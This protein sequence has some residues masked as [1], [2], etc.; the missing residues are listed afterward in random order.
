M[1]SR[2]LEI[3]GGIECS[4]NR[5]S[6]I[7]FDQL[8]FS[9]HYKREA[10][11]ELIAELGFKK[12]RYPVLWEKHQPRENSEVNFDF[13]GAALT[14]LKSLGVEPIVGLVHHGSGPG[15]APIQSDR[16][17]RGLA[18]YAKKVAEAFP[19]V[20]YYTPVNEPLTTGRF[21]GLYGIWYPHYRDSAAFVRL[22][23][24]ECKATA[25]AMKAIREVNP[26]AKLVHTEDLGKTYSTPTLKYQAD[27]ENVRRWL[28]LDLLMGKVTPE[29]D[30]WGYLMNIGIKPEEMAFFNEN[31][32]IPD[33][34]GFNYYLTSE[35][36][37]DERIENFPRN[38]IGGNGRHKYADV[39][40]V[41]VQL[42]EESGLKVLLREAWDRFKLPLALTEVHLGC[43]REEQIRWFASVR[44]Q[45]SSLRNEGVDIRAMTA[46]A[47]F[48]SHGWSNLLTNVPGGRYEPGVFD[49]SNGEP[50]PTALARLIKA[51][52][53]GTQFAHPV[54]EGKGWWQ[55][56]IRVLYFSEKLV[57]KIS[58]E[59]KSSQP[60]IIVG[61]TGTL[62]R[63]FA[64]VCD[65]RGIDYRLL[66]RNELDI[67]NP[68]QIEKVIKE[69]RPWAVINAAGF[70]RVD[71]AESDIEGC[72]SANTTGPANL[73][74]V[75]N[76]LGV[77]LL[78][79]SSDLVFDGKKNESYL[80]SDKV[81]P[82]NI[83][84][85]SKAEAEKMVKEFDPSALIIRTSAFFGP[86]DEYNFVY[87]VLNS[88]RNQSPVTVAGDAFISPTYV[89]DLV[90]SSLDLLL[91]DEYGVWHLANA[92]E[93]TWSKLA[94]EVA[95][96]G[97]CCSHL[98]R[99]VT[100]EEMNHIAKRPAYS[101]LNSERGLLLPS[102]DDALNRYFQEQ[103]L[104]V[105]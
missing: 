60:I 55:R 98:I 17:A 2:E 80:E 91:D 20:T 87:Y 21:C 51:H 23:I 89:P 94:A 48:G 30:F 25:L 90:N 47:M 37:L 34:L 50:R 16:F 88:L 61:K 65:I 15:Y 62:G 68:Q 79:F 9:G 58:S 36:Y 5:V 73:A 102:L 93:I 78:T 101:V 100:M 53:G 46:W 95:L 3:W 41:R 86:W 11:I 4:I 104:L 85:R 77:K 49:V 56:D 76:K 59:T 75:C 40:A 6:D 13:A 84:G 10:D 63:A 1:H 29:H 52:T 57:R 35:R 12:L 105:W 7:Y 67:S 54:M 70:V 72:F 33:I 19:W 82:L 32:C 38:V 81:A 44:E 31:P 97:D 103:E 26:A 22:L 39:E 74:G 71:D 24:N 43:T 64:R 8:D 27:F 96:K 92:G 45:I 18:E 66:S 28:S 42:T 14:K 83:Y 69:K 99:E